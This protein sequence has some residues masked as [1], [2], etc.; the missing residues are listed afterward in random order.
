MFLLLPIAVYVIDS[1][2][3]KDSELLIFCDTQAGGGGGGVSLSPNFGGHKL[4]PRMPLDSKV[5]KRYC[6]PMK[7]QFIVRDS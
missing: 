5:E 6:F 4:G 3:I 1:T 7:L 2:K